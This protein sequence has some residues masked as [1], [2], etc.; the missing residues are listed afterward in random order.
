MPLPE[1]L[2]RVREDRFYT[3]KVAARD[4]AGNEVVE[5]V[6]IR[7]PDHDCPPPS[8]LEVVKQGDPACTP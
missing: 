8:T 2:A 1:R 3:V 7:V 5:E 4:A 6:V